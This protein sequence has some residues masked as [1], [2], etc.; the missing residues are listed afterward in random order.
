M[1]QSTLKAMIRHS[2]KKMHQRQRRLLKK[3]ANETM[4]S[5]N[6]KPKS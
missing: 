3:H 6:R 2:L 4:A 5:A 1:K